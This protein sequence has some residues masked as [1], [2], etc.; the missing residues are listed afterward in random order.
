MSL[1]LLE[2]SSLESFDHIWVSR[3]RQDYVTTFVQ[4]LSLF[5]ICDFHFSADVLGALAP[6]EFD[7]FYTEFLNGVFL[8]T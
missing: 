5:D 8:C 6:L 3:V 7:A 2:S 4:Q 1:K